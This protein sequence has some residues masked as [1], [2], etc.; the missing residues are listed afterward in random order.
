MRNDT[1]RRANSIDLDDKAALK[2][3]V[4]ECAGNRSRMAR[5]LAE[6]GQPLSRQAISV[7]LKRAG[8]LVEA[9]RLSA[10]DRKR[11]PRNNLPKSA[12]RKEREVI[13]DA[14]ARSKRYADAPA[15]LDMTHATMYRRIAEYEITTAMVKRRR[16]KLA[17]ARAA[18]RR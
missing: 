12:A 8:L 10:S 7:R 4:V 18:R 16:A 14:L 17:K 1:A 6:R 2:A 11:G 3:L 15:L 5:A 9:D 13:L